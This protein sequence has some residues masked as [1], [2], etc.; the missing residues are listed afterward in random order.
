M[1]IKILVA[2][3]GSALVIFSFQNCQK[4]PYADEVSSLKPS[5]TAKVDLQN[6]KISQLNVYT[7]ESE[8]VARQ[9]RTYELYVS[10][11]LQIDLATGQI[12]VVS[13]V[14]N[15]PID[16]CLTD[17]LKNELLGILKTSKVCKTA[18]ETA[19]GVVCTMALIPPYAQLTT[20]A[21]QFNLGA[22][23]DGCRRNMD[24]LCGDQSAMLK[25]FIAALK[26]KYKS[27]TCPH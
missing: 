24:D 23:S 9:G 11:T 7:Q 5:V 18:A 20:D 21:A 19:P 4:A 16:Y 17:S 13:D 3:I 22:A 1:N 12:Q 27:L 6:E 10:K 8:M 2:I 26:T 25:G 15:V 14:S